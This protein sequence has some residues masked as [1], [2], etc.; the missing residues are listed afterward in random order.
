[1]RFEAL[2]ANRLDL[3]AVEARYSSAY[4]QGYSQ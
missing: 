1:V 4:L 2:R 3:P